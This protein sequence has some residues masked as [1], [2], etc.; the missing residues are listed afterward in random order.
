MANILIVE[1]SPIIRR[2]LR[3]IFEKMGHRVVAEVEN[4][5][6]ALEAYNKY[7]IDLTTMDIQLPGIDGIETVRRIL[8]R[9]KNAAIVM[10]SSLKDRNK[11]FEAI[12]LGAKHYIVKPFA[13]H[14]VIQVVNAVLGAQPVLTPAENTARTEARPNEPLPL[15]PRD[16]S[17]KEVKEREPLQ[18]KP[19][20]LPSLPFELV[21]KDGRVVLMIQ[22]HITDANVRFLCNCLQGLLYFRKAKYVLELWEPI[23][24]DEGFRLVVEFAASV[25]ARNGTVSVVTDDPVQLTRLKAKLR[26][27]VYRS[28]A[29]IKW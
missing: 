24:H 15:S 26:D 20:A 17:E 9:H 7:E 1:D 6:E 18:L 23:T 3:E 8:E 11:V 27:G 16:A 2:S 13:E 10:I 5:A 29:E 19:P 12:K 22:R 25:R 28:Y 14:K 4:G 21:I